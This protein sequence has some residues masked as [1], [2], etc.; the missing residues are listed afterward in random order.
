MRKS[1][2]SVL[3]TLQKSCENRKYPV[4]VFNKKRVF[5]PRLFFEWEI[6]P[7]FAEFAVLYQVRQ[8]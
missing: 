6:Y 8:N 4:F 3:K 5:L 2:V 1:S 7:V